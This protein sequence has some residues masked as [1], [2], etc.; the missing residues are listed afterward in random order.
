MSLAP[1]EDLL[2][3]RAHVA[4]LLEV[5][6]RDELRDLYRQLAARARTAVLGEMPPG[7]LEGRVHE[8]KGTAANLA[9]GTLAREAEAVLLALRR[10]GPAAAL[11]ERAA[12][13]AAVERVT[14]LL[15]SD[16]L[17]RW[18]ASI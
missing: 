3:D 16:R 4:E 14:A 8:L 6:S 7:E 11:P 17:D 1:D 9:L 2:P 12:L 5:L 13:L 10:D 18:L 15:E